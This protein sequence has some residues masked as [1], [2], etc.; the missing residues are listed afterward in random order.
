MK[1]KDKKSIKNIDEEINRAKNALKKIGRRLT[2]IDFK[3]GK[4][5]IR[6]DIRAIKNAKEILKNRP[7]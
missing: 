1:S 3:Y 2:L 7:E 5:L 6:S 4:S